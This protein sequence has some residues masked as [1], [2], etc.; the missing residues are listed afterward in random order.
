[1][2]TGHGSLLSSIDRTILALPGIALQVDD[3][4]HREMSLPLLRRSGSVLAVDPD[5]SS[6]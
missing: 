6:S 5:L 1:L 4:A 3:P 2:H